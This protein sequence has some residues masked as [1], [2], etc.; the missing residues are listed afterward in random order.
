MK[1]ICFFTYN[2]F[3]LGGIQRVVTVLA[4]ALCEHYDVYIQCYDAPE[5]ENRSLYSLDPRVHMIFSKRYKYQSAIRKTLKKLNKKYGI[6]EKINN[7]PLIE[8]A[9]L[10]PEERRLYRTI[11]NEY[12]IDVAIAVGGFESCILGSIAESISA[13]TIGWQ[14]NSYKAYYETPGMACWGMGH[15]IDKYFPML[16]RFVVLNEYDQDEFL[17]KRSFDCQT[18]HNPKSFVS[19]NQ[20]V[21]N[22]KQFIAAGRFIYAKGFDILIQAFHIFAQNNSDWNL[23]IYGKGKDYSYIK[24]RVID[25]GLEQRVQ[26]PG[27]SDKMEENM[28]NA[29]CYLLSSRWE[30][31]PM[32]V[33][34]ALEIGLPVISFDISAIIPLVDNGVEGI[35]VPQYDINAFADAMLRI[36]ESEE[37]RIKMG[38]AAKRKADQFSVDRIVEKWLQLL[39]SLY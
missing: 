19:D 31:M 5:A 17:K 27:F 13:K 29:S 32:V 33:L 11:I 20:A 25:L 3:D 6:L 16:D 4:S 10:L 37:K 26:L 9:Y 35:V 38:N 15:I 23:V 7:K 14:H 34:E 39:E 21:L 22:N 8:Y 24:K 28:L 30:G 1:K 2:M 18:I 12:D 36:A